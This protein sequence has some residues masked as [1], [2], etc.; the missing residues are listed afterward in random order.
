MA[1]N[2]GDKNTV[3]H[4]AFH[5]IRLEQ[6]ELGRLIDIRVFW[7]EKYNPFP[8]NRVEHVHFENISFHGH[9][10]NPS[11]IAGFDADRTVSHVHF[12]NL[13]LNGRLITSAEAGNFQCNEFQSHVTF[14]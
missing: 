12:R 3:R 9:C 4:V 11:V 7:N 14:E 1:I 5:D 13:R 10:P 6:F 8:G 2:A